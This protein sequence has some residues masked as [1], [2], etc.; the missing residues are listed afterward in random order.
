M[1]YNNPCQF[2]STVGGS[3]I[4]DFYLT[5][6][7]TLSDVLSQYMS[8][9]IPG[10]WLALS[11]AVILTLLVPSMPPGMAGLVLI[12]VSALIFIRTRDSALSASIF[13]FGVLSL[14]GLLP[15]FVLCA[16]VLIVATRELIFSYSKGRPAE[17]ALSL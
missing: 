2:R 14:I 9:I 12:L 8:M 6:T 7:D 10:R 5:D 13:I 11:A 15:V 4:N 16:T 3:Q 17:Y 1:R